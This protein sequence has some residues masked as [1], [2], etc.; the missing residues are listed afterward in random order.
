MIGFMEKNKADD[1]ESYL[2]QLQFPDSSLKLLPLQYILVI[3]SS[4]PTNRE[5]LPRFYKPFTTL[6]L[7]L[8]CFVG[9]LNY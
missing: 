4:F 5:H 8:L 3:P 6:I 9:T 1:A 7:A 2:L